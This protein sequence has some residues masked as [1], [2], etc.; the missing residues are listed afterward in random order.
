MLSTRARAETVWQRRQP[1]LVE[2]IISK[3]RHNPGY[4]RQLGHTLFQLMVPLDFKS[5]VREQSRLL[6]VL[7]AYTANLPWELLQVDGE[8]L[9]LRTRMIR[10]LATSHYRPT[11]RTANSNAV[12]I[13]V[14][15]NTHGFNKRFPGKF[16]QLDDLEGAV[17]EAAAI[18][19]SLRKVGW[20][21]IVITPPDREALDVFNVLFE[22]PYRV[23]V[24]GAHGLFEAEAK[25]G[26]A[27]TGVVLSDGL[28]ITAVEISQMEVVPELVFL[29]CCHLGGIRTPNPTL[30]VS[31]ISWPI[32]WRAN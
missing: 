26:R 31:L 10:Q 9:V 25:D 24:I 20:N 13:I 1:G 27:Y 14:N 16:E 3:Q 19:Q 18:E 11:I 7:D 8:A 6:L 23:L 17:R 28:L 2:D 15:P 29:S 12:C 32:A 21:D 4:D 22:R 30:T 5:T